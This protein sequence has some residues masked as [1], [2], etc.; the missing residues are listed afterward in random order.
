[1]SQSQ[2]VQTLIMLTVLLIVHLC[3]PMKPNEM[4]AVRGQA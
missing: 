2:V 1:M 3:P 4:M